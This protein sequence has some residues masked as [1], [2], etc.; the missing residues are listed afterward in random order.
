MEKIGIPRIVAGVAAI[1]GLGLPGLAGTDLFVA[2]GGDDAGPGT[3]DRPFATLARARDAARDGKG[4][5]PVSIVLRGGTHH[6]RE[7]LVLSP[8]DSGAPGAPVEYR[9]FEGESP[10]VSRSEEHTSELQSP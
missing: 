4:R 7:T 1:I 2:P 3:L 5:G 9:A 6:L 8:E 10:V